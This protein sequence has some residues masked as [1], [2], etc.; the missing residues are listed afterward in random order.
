MR[1]SRGKALV[2]L[3]LAGACGPGCVH[4]MLDD[5]GLPGQS[6]GTYRVQATLTSN[7]C[8]PGAFG[9]LDAWEFEVKLAREGSVIYW[10]NGTE[11]VEGSLAADGRAFSFSDQL[12]MPL[13]ERKG[14][15]AGCTMFRQDTASGTLDSADADKV[16]GFTG[17]LTYGYD[18]EKGS[19][20]S[21]V[22]AQAGAAQLPC[23][24]DYTIT[25][26]R[27]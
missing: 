4:D 24:L 18:Q 8:G 3:V 5:D 2:V 14:A 21:A 22:L 25:A 19:D 6:M 17:S 10:N 7:S 27:E 26:T 16:T 1:G 11:L 9:A 23:K 20:C 12:T 13:S 15:Q